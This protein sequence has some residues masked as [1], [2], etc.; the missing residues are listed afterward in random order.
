MSEVAISTKEAEE[1]LGK[2]CGTYIT[3]ETAKGIDIFETEEL[4]DL[5]IR[6]KKAAWRKKQ[7]CDGG[8]NRKQN[9]NARRAR[10]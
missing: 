7:Q 10:T 8:R 6:M 2:P 3:L 1:M 5:L 4:R 9:G